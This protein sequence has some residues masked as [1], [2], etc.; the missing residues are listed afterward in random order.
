[1]GFTGYV[2]GPAQGVVQDL[3]EPAITI[4]SSGAMYVTGHVIGA[5]TT[6][7]P[8]YVSTNSGAT[9]T[10]LPVVSTISTA[11]LSGS[12]P[13][14]GDEGIIV[15]DGTHAWMVDAQ[16]GVTMSVQGWCSN[17]ATQCFYQPDVY[18]A[19][20][21][22]CG[23]GVGSVGTD[24][25]WAA[26]A[27]VGASNLLLLENNGYLGTDGNVA[28][29]ALMDVTPGLPVGAVPPT[30]N[31]CAGGGWVDGYI[32]GPPSMSTG[33]RFIVPQIWW[34]TSPGP[35]LAPTME[36]IT[37]TTAGGVLST[38]N[39]AAFSVVN[40]LLSC[41]SNYGFTGISNSGTFY[42]AA[43]DTAN[44]KDIKVAVTTTAASGS[45]KTGTLATTD[46]IAF[47]W[48]TGSQTGEG[49]LLSW[50]ED[51]SAGACTNV[52]FHTAHV[53]LNASGNPV[54]SDST[55][56]A[57]AMKPC[58]DLMGSSV[59]PTGNAAVVI[60]SHANQCLDA[61]SPN[62]PHPLRVY[63]QTSGPTI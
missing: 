25:P 1:M 37:G 34:A 10:Q 30:W 36:V 56:V 63:V 27:K 58:G 9:W 61:V 29:I 23:V 32:P 14:G 47:M 19:Q 49:A 43:A 60:F 46:P 18:D 52:D 26:E 5:Y 51:K 21:A 57:S 35:G 50:A 20:A 62:L 31:P 40:T 38:T 53:T 33:G 54:F 42:I 48:I 6:G 11:P 4:S 39:A 12:A 59:G 55:L 8:A 28:Q 13:P 16:D 45:F 7:T 22:P 15:A 2:V 3:Y 17:G 44:N 41:S 24:R